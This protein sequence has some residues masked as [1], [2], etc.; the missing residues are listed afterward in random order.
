MDHTLEFHKACLNKL[1]RICGRINLTSKEKKQYKKPYLSE[2]F[3]SDILFF[4]DINI[5]DDSDEKHSA[6]L[7]HKC[8]A[9]F[10]NIKKSHSANSLNTAKHQLTSTSN[11]WCHFSPSKSIAECSSCSFCSGLTQGCVVTQ[12]LNATPDNDNGLTHSA[13]N[14]QETQ[15]LC[16]TEASSDPIPVATSTPVKQLHLP[17]KIDSS[18]SPIIKQDNLF[19]VSLGKS[20]NDAMIP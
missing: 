18:T 10:R 15:D 5:K 8:V 19:S 12:T 13:D 16:N 3:A 2:H 17:L 20:R 4:F 1:C 9:S 6:Y 7:C 14:G 11:V